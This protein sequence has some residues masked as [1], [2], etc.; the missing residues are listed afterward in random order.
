MSLRPPLPATS[1]SGDGEVYRFGPGVCFRVRGG[2]LVR[3]HFVRE[4]GPAADEPDPAGVE[5]DLHWERTPRSTGHALVAGGHKTA[6]WRV[7]LSSPD[8]DPLRASIALQGGPPSFALS[9]VQGYFVEPLIAV[10]A[11][12]SDMVLLAGAAVEEGG[13]ALLLVGR[14]RSGKSSLTARAIASGRGVLGDDQVLV[15]RSGRCWP[16]PR[17]IRVYSDLR[18]TAPAAHAHLN[19]RSQ[20]ALEAR[21]VAKATSRGAVA[22][23][24]LLDP[25][26]LGPWR[27][28]EPLPIRR[29]VVIERSPSASVLAI[30]PIGSAEAIDAALAALAAQREHLVGA[31]TAWNATLDATL[32]SEKDSLTCAFAHASTARMAVPAAWCAPRA[33]AELD[34]WLNGGGAGQI[35]Q[36]AGRGEN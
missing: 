34:E 30:E 12:R 8:A 26:Q 21:R 1:R 36:R 20:L 22:P 24:L 27:R 11:A 32:R 33:I 4:Y 25:A 16:F 10:S 31:S 18:S 2:K 6:R 14:S 35:R 13:G 9:L 5:A 29:V 19:R 17:R 15:D 28:S 23:S 7:G 3:R